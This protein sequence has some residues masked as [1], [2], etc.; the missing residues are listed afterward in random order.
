[1]KGFQSR[2]IDLGVAAVFVLGTW[3]L[4]QPILRLWW[5]YDDFYHFRHLIT[6]RPWW[7][8]FDASEYRRLEAKVLTPLLFFSLD[9]DRRLFGLDACPFYLHQLVAFALCPAAIYAVLR[10]WLRRLWAAV[11]AWVFLT[12]PVIASLAPLLFVR[13]YIEVILLGSLAAMAWAG[14][15]RSMGRKAW[16]LALLSAAFYFAAAMTKEIA[17]PLI[18]LLPLLPDPEG[19]PRGNFAARLRLAI[20]HAVLLAVYMILRFV[21]LG[22]FGGGYGFKVDRGQLPV[23]ALTL[24]GKIVAEFLG[25]R[26]SAAAVL[27]LITLAAGTLALF[28]LRGFRAFLLTGAA[29]ALA[30]LTVLVVSTQMEPRYAVASWVV[31]VVAFAAGCQALAEKKR[32]IGAAV[33]SIACLSGLVLNRQDWAIRFASAERMSAEDRFL[34][35]MREGDVLRHPL[36][37][38]A[39]LGELQ[40]MKE[41]VFHHP[42]GG[43]WFQDDLYL[44]LHPGPMGRVWG[45]DPEARRVVDITA[46]I[47]AL[48]DQ[49]CSSIRWDAPLSASFRDSEGALRWDLG[50]YPKGRYSFLMGDGAA[51]FEMPRS[52]AFQMRE[53]APFLPLRVMYES[54]E[55]WVT[56]SPELRVP[57]VEGQGVRWGRGAS[58]ATSLW[59][60]RS[61]PHTTHGEG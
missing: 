43:R 9:L 56:Y 52:A 2:W 46:R 48:R 38:T 15:V 25:G 54:P 47:P 34:F 16:I 11:G 17:V 28:L 22:A 35:D 23:L 24:P 45:Y 60:R 5:T 12:G 7:Y 4:Y 3:L 33:G 50:P 44:C 39:S 41:N 30:L 37:L 21:W 29:L 1:M 51:V 6:G 20:P 55:G 14:A 26:S 27:F 19:E 18:A 49:F 57:L 58:A 53:R 36:L 40:W 13:H 10:I 61:S 42:H 31:A 59:P 32:W 8:F